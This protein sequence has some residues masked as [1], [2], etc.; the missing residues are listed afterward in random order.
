MGGVTI[1]VA[2][3][4][5][6]APPGAKIPPN[7]PRGTGVVVAADSR[8]V[9]SDGH[10]DDGRKVYRI[11]DDAVMAF[12]GDVQ[13]AERAIASIQRMLTRLRDVSGGGPHQDPTTVAA[14]HLRNAYKTAN[15]R[16]RAGKRA[17]RRLSALVGWRRADGATGVTA[18]SSEANFR[19]QIHRSVVAVGD[20]TAIL[21]FYKHFSDALTNQWKD[22]NT[23]ETVG[24][25]HA[26]V[27][28][29]MDMAIREHKGGTVGGAI[30]SIVIS[31]EGMY[32]QDWGVLDLPKGAPTPTS[33]DVEILKKVTA[34]TRDLKP[35]D[36]R[37]RERSTFALPVVAPRGTPPPDGITVID[38]D[39]LRRLRQPSPLP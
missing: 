37:R 39:Q 21:A 6:W 13:A 20:E 25:W 38:L 1:A 5:P 2:A 29:A 10:T 17:R 30:Q 23:P 27:L 31:P 3:C 16:A 32:E 35:L 22:G 33:I 8:F 24:H 36:S 34:R 19:P 4:F 7:F 11:A 15:A 9:Y 28:F 14:L 18:F 12:S 26:H